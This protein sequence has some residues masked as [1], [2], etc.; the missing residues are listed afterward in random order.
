MNCISLM[1]ATFIG[2]IIGCIISIII[3][4]NYIFK[5]NE[6]ETFFSKKKEK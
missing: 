4:L 6:N 3:L 2:T 5:K 1:I